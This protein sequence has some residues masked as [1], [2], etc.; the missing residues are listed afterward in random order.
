[1]TLEPRQRD[2][3]TGRKVCIRS[4]KIQPESR[5]SVLLL[6]F[7]W[8]EA[9]GRPCVTGGYLFLERAVDKA[10]PCESRLLCEM[11]RN[12][13]SLKHLTAAAC[14]GSAAGIFFFTRLVK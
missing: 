3:K 6:P 4:V 10:M 12:Y 14:I 1:M 7:F 13:Y 2:V 9:F 11:R 5:P 8:C